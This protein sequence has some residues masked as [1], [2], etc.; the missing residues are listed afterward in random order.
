MKHFLKVILACSIMIGTYYYLDNSLERV[1]GA[2]LQDLAYAILANNRNPS[3]KKQ[4]EERL[5]ITLEKMKSGGFDIDKGLLNA[6]EDNSYIHDIKWVSISHGNRGWDEVTKGRG[7]LDNIIL[8]F[9]VIDNN[10]SLQIKVTFFVNPK[11]FPFVFLSNPSISKIAPMLVVEITY[12]GKTVKYIDTERID[13]NG[14]ISL[15]VFYSEEATKSMLKQFV[16]KM[17]R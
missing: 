9:K 13:N 7:G 4:E 17:K 5:D 1:Q 2:T 8:N 10:L 11:P 15:V 14:Y 3:Y 6:L 16:K 12:K